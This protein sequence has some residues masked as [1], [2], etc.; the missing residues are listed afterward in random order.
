MPMCLHVF[1]MFKQ[2]A[3]MSP[4]T[5]RS[6]LIVWRCVLVTPRCHR[7]TGGVTPVTGRMTRS[8]AV[9]CGAAATWKPWETRTAASRTPAPRRRPRSRCGLTPWSTPSSDPGTCWTPRGKTRHR[10]SSV[11][12]ATKRGILTILSL[13][14]VKYSV[15]W[16]K[17]TDPSVPQLGINATRE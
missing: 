11:P 17:P 15:Y 8:P 5:R 14:D 12:G 4:I 16:F 1:W 6:F 2:A 7:M 3:Y 10:F 9:G 13:R